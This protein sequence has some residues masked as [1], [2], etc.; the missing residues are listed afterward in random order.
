MPRKP[1]RTPERSFL[2]R[3]WCVVVRVST[4]TGAQAGA[5]GPTKSG[6]VGK[7]GCA[8]L[9]PMAEREVPED[10]GGDAGG[11]DGSRT[12]S[13]DPSRPHGR[14]PLRHRGV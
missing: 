5:L 1:Q 6:A 8:G 9:L 4:S 2:G 13:R 12:R 7:H 3:C 14:K 11:Q 10:C